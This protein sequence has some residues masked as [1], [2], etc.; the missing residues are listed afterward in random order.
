MSDVGI[1]EAKNSKNLRECRLGDGGVK[2][3]R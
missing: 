3:V 1:D 2:V